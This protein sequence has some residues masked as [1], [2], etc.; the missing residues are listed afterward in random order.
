MQEILS[1]LPLTLLHVATPISLLFQFFINAFASLSLRAPIVRHLL[2]PS[3]F[4]HFTNCPIHAQ[5]ISPNSRAPSYRHNVKYEIVNLASKQPQSYHLCV[6]VTMSLVVR[7]RGSPWIVC[8]FPAS[9]P[10]RTEPPGEAC[11][12]RVYML[13]RLF[14]LSSIDRSENGTLRF[15]TSASLRDATPIYRKHVQFD[16]A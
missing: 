4:A 5:L 6:C 16:N 1:S 15:A 14:I 2:F 12:E 10:P 9:P 3:A 13:A 7:R 11:T 8:F